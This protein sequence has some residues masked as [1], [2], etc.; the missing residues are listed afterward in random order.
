MI[1][2]KLSG[3]L[4]NQMFQYSLGV[5]LSKKTNSRLMLDKSFLKKKS[6]KANYTLRDY[7][8]D[9]F[10]RDLN[11]SNLLETIKC[12]LYYFYKIAY[13][14]NK[15]IGTSFFNNKFILENNNVSYD[16]RV[17][18]VSKNILLI[19]NWQNEKYFSDSKD[20]VISKFEF[21][22]PLNA[23][24]SERLNRISQSNSI[25][26][27][28][29]RGDYVDILSANKNHGVCSLDYYRKSI[30]YILSKIDNPTF[31]VFSDDPIWVE[32]NLKIDEAHEYVTGNIGKMSYV[33]MQLMSQCK[34][35]IIANSSFSWWG[36]WLNQNPKKNIIAPKQWF[37]GVEKNS[38]KKELVP[39]TWTRI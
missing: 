27:H 8:L 21:K 20:L 6:L 7:E 30:D 39:S 22:L 28:V 1:C 23:I 17:N 14:L 15:L 2:V 33:D 16:D 5:A 9:I 26:I 18:I 36:A 3:G 4:G 31:F 10:S 35:N 19:G 29:R 25:S 13:H 11:D 12:R 38:N 32:E 24:N 37:A 34:H